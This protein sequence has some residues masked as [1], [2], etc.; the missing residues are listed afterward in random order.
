VVHAAL[1]LP[2]SSPL[3][4]P[5][6]GACTLISLASPSARFAQDSSANRCATVSKTKTIKIHNSITYEKLK[7]LVI[8]IFRLLSFLEP[9]V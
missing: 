5:A 9:T 4:G 8:M 3:V 1:Q 7:S 2:P 6:H